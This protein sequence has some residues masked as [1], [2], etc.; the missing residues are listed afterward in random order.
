MSGKSLSTEVAVM[1][2]DITYIKE[3]LDHVNSKI[4]EFIR[5]ADEKYAYKEM[6]SLVHENE[7][8]IDGIDNK[9]AYYAGALAVFFILVNV[10]IKIY[11]GW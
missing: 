10:V 6:E 3:K 5:C 1:K 2:T 4:D 8:R 7:R 9:L 11:F